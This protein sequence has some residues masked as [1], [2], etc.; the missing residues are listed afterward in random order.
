MIK[1]GQSIYV[2]SI[3]LR[4]DGSDGI[5][6]YLN[7]C[8]ISFVAYLRDIKHYKGDNDNTIIPYGEEKYK[9]F[10]VFTKPYRSINTASITFFYYS[11]D[12]LVQNKFI[13]L[14]SHNK[15][16]EI[17]KTFN[18]VFMSTTNLLS[19]KITIDRLITSLSL[20]TLPAWQRK[21]YEDDY[22]IL[23]SQNKTESEKKTHNDRALKFNLFLEK[24]PDKYLQSAKFIN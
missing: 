10:I 14:K 13:L 4:V 23:T 19:P 20:I 9:Q 18:L 17:A 7:D 11:G 5:G 2:L 15:Y 24:N 1:T 12:K 16:N 8:L 3:I 6:H 21:I 22:K